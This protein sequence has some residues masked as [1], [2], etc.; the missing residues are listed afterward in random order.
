[1]YRMCAVTH[2]GVHFKEKEDDKRIFTLP[3]K[4]IEWTWYPEEAVSEDWLIQA[5]AKLDYV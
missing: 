3:W 4:K 1:M 5:G 2:E